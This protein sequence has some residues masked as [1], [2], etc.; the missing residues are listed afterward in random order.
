MKT[1]TPLTTTTIQYLAAT[2][3]E[4]LRKGDKAVA[5]KIMGEIL[6]HLDLSLKQLKALSVRDDLSLEVLNSASHL[7]DYLLKSHLD[8]ALK[9][10]AALFKK[11]AGLVRVLT[12]E[13]SYPQLQLLI[14]CRK[15]NRRLPKELSDFIKEILDY[16]VN[17][18]GDFWNHFP[19]ID[20]LAGK[21][22]KLFI[23]CQALR[24]YR[25]NPNKSYTYQLLDELVP[26][27]IESDD[28]EVHLL[29]A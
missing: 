1:P 29:Y 28:P 8:E 16:K 3:L 21:L 27:I 13:L 11:Y 10:T 17:S 14:N 9:P 15:Y 18:I 23:Q 5:Q 26:A 7:C 20:I 2:A 12:P 19:G 4:P 25:Y 6:E 22:R 24:V